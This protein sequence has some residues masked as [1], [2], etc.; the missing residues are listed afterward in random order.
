MIDTAALQSGIDLRDLAGRYTTLKVESARELSGACPKC[1]GRDRLHVT[2]GWWFCRQC[3][4]KRGDAIEFVRW[5]QGVDFKGAAAF[6]G[7]GLPGRKRMVAQPEP[8]PYPDADWQARAWRV[9]AD[10]EQFLWSDGK[11]PAKARAYLA[12]RG[13]LEST[14]LAF[15]VGYTLGGKFYGHK[16]EPGIVLPWLRGDA[17]WKVNVRRRTDEPKYGAVYG[18][19]CGGLYGADYLCQSDTLLVTE[20]EFDAMLCWQEAGD[21]C[22]VTTV[23]SATGK[24]GVEW[25]PLLSR[26]R[27]VLVCTD[28]DADGHKAATYWLS[29][30][31]DKGR[32]LQVPVDPPGKDITDYHMAGGD[33]RGWLLAAGDVCAQTVPGAG[34]AA[35]VNQGRLQELLDE[36]FTYADAKCL[37]MLEAG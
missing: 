31:G 11:W 12:R 7:G 1:G 27:R 33:V 28:N 3:H 17:I 26:Y 23:G 24:T 36:G 13:L 10:C 29:L 5:L 25:F 22:D 15:R 4:E 19:V 30:V 8:K 2:A 18:G 16:L 35:S 9:V 20:G 14:A 32:R 6:L 34:G 37:A 21:V